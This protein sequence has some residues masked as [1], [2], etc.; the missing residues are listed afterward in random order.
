MKAVD[1]GDGYCSA[2]GQVYKRGVEG[3]RAQA[4]RIRHTQPVVDGRGAPAMSAAHLPG[5]RDSGAAVA[6]ALER[7]RRRVANELHD[8]AIQQLVLARILI[9][10]T[11][12]PGA[13]DELE[14]VRQLLDDSLEQLRSLMLGLTPA[15]LYRDGLCPAIEWLCEQLGT[16]WRLDCSCRVEGDP[17]TSPNAITETLF[18][19]ARELMTNVGRHAQALTCEVVLRYSDDR[20][21]LT[22]RDDGIGIDPRR[23]AG[24]SHGDNGGFGLLSL[25]ARIE[26]MGGEL[27]LGAGEKG[28]TRAVLCLPL[29]R[30]DL[31]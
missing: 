1:D 23:A 21:E 3:D 7:E 10:R 17:V 26:E 16:R 14:R 28:G 25:R 9:D 13:T 27:R 30:V 11:R 2:S 31:P 22:V 29:G 8:T 4:E 20:V 12:A 6:L 5:T 24:A 19:G 18:Q 15:V